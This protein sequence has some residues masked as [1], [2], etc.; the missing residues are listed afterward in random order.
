MAIFL[1]DR[2]EAEKAYKEGALAEGTEIPEFE[3]YSPK[4]EK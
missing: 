3:K 4:E 2:D 1:A